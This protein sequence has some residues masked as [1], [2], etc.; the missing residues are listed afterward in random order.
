MR[1]LRYFAAL[2]LAGHFGRAADACFVSQ[3]AFSVAIRELETT[4]GVQLVDRT[5]KQVAITPVGREIAAQARLV[6]R[7]TEQ[8]VQ[9]AGQMQKPLTGRLTLGVIPTIAPFLLPRILPQVRKRY[10]ELQLLIREGQTESIVAELADG[11]LDMVLLALPYPLRNVETVM[12]FRDRFLLACHRNTKLVDPEHF[13]VNRVNAESVLLLEDGHCMRDH[14]LAACRV[15]NFDVVNRF[16][17]SSLLTLIEM[18]EADLGVTFVPEIAITAG[19]LKGSV[20]EARPLTADSPARELALVWRR[21]FRR[22]ND[23]AALATY[24]RGQLAA[25]RTRRPPK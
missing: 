7:D 11:R 17:A 15:N 9:I 4:L 23:L 21:S 19:L 13:A 1:Q 8:L 12:L 22:E 6:L 14:A 10:P 3:S 5:T 18:V 2:E 24:M 20:V 16:A 25:L